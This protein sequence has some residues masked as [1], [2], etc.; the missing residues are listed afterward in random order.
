MNLIVAN[1]SA[2]CLIAMY[3]IAL[4]LSA[5]CFIAMPFIDTMSN[6]QLPL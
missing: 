2:D 1:P 4:N 5:D 3:L 6:S